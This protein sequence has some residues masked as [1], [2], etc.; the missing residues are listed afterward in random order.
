MKLQCPPA[1]SKDRRALFLWGTVMLRDIIL[2]LL[3]AILLIISF[4]PY[5]APYG[6]WVALVPL[7]LIIMGKDQKY[8]FLLSQICGSIYILGVFNWILEVENYTFLHHTILVVYLGSYVAFFGLMINLT[9]RWFGAGWALAAA[10]FVWVFLEYIRSNFFFIALPWGLLAHSQYQSPV[11]IQIASI[12]GVY[13]ISFLIVLVNSAVAAAI[14]LSGSFFPKFI[15]QLPGSISKRSG[16]S[17]I[18]LAAISLALTLIYGFQIIEQPLDGDPIKVSVVQGNIEQTQ[19]WDKK[20]S[21]YILETYNDLTMKASM[22]MPDLIVW[23]ETSTP[24]SIN[25]NLSIHNQ[26]RKLSR[27]TGTYLLVGSA[28]RQKFRGEDKKQANYYNSAFLIPPR[29]KQQ[30][31]NKIRLF[32][33]GEYLP[34]K[35]I[36]PWSFISVPEVG[37]YVP[38]KK[39]KIFN[40]PAGQFGVTICWENIFPD[41]VRQFVKRGAGLIINITNEAWFGET[42]A[43]YQFLSMSVMRAVENRVSVIRSANTGVSGFIDPYGRIVGR[44]KN[45]EQKDIFVRGFLTRDIPVVQGKTFYTRF[46]NIFVYLCGIISAFLIFRLIVGPGR[47]Q[48]V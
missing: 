41:F 30:H 1:L 45:D 5:N 27:N 43:P 23:P 37:G 10:P 15:L 28:Q 39:F 13:G 33:F 22:D 11:V 29:G 40:H 32:P 35:D 26:L 7:L 3:S 34:M 42:A 6:V 48:K 2:A 14:L 36:F 19:K 24:G 46:G 31:Y 9:S 4:P 47:K 44:V 18:G 20:Y 25:Q 12:S 17:I 21:R 8:S 38:G 16:L